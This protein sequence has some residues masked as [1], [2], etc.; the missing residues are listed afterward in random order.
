MQL[1]RGSKLYVRIDYKIWG[2][3]MSHQ[4]FQDHLNYLKNIARERYFIG[5]G[6]SNTDGGMCLFEAEN[7]EDAQNINKNDPIIER[8]LYRYE[9]L[10]WNLVILSDEYYGND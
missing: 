6:F 7:F 8:G 10:E 2:K 5:G 9:L 1:K 4:D 3:D